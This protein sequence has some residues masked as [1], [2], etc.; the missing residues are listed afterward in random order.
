MGFITKKT[1]G[2]TVKEDVEKPK[3]EETNPE[4]EK[5]DEPED[6]DKKTETKEESKEETKPTEDKPTSQVKFGFVAN[7]DGSSTESTLSKTL[8]TKPT[9]SFGFKPSTTKTE[10]SSSTTVSFGF[11]PPTAESTTSESKT[12]EQPKLFPT[13]QSSTVAPLFS[14]DS[15]KEPL[16]AGFVTTNNTWGPLKLSFGEIKKDTPFGSNIQPPKSSTSTTGIPETTKS[17]VIPS[18]KDTKPLPT[19]EENEEVQFEGACMFY[20][21]DKNEKSWKERGGK[22]VV[23][24]NSQR[25]HPNKSRILIRNSVSHRVVLNS[26]IFEQM[27]F[28]INEKQKNCIR[29]TAFVEVE[30]KEES[31]ASKHELSICMVRFKDQ[32][33]ADEAFKVLNAQKDKLGAEGDVTPTTKETEPKEKVTEPKEAST[34]QKDEVK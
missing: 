12:D 2:S 32:A 10:T 3:E 13:S 21:F 11:K 5:K 28:I 23:H 1:N 14:T 34:D 30:S 29:F 26:P 6:K 16:N 15:K 31:D 4:T 20:V 27:T 22:S 24:V 33:T 7:K 18:S 17:S 25:D 8:E 19:G 9:V